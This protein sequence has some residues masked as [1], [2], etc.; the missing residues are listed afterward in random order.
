MKSVW[1]GAV[2][3]FVLNHMEQMGHEQ[4]AQWLEGNLDIASNMESTLWSLRE[5]K[6]TILR[7]LNA[8]SPAE[9]FDMYQKERPGN[10]ITEKDKAIVRIGKELEAMKAYLM[11]L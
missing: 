9:V 10:R 1:R 4:L 5:H 2:E 8:L 6:E 7:E 11:S 3:R